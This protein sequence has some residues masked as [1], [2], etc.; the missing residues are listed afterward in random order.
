MVYMSCLISKDSCRRRDLEEEAEVERA[1]PEDT[2]SM[3]K[4]VRPSRRSAEG[5]ASEVGLKV[6]SLVD[7]EE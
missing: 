4:E 2:L 7:E 3:L 6:V 1:D 5:K